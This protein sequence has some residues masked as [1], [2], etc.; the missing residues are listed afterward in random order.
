MFTQFG[1]VLRKIRIDRGML[2][3]DMAEGFGVSS[4]FLSA[5]ETGKKSIPNGF[6]E[7]AALFLGYAK[8]SAEWDELQDAAAISK[9][10]IAL[11]TQGLTQKHQETALAFA[12]HFEEMAP[13]D[14]DK[15]LQLLNATKKRREE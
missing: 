14:L 3:K 5:V 11:A 13:A 7:R 2:L 9:G 6:V 8:G 12:R 15:V 4:A 1:K 10:E